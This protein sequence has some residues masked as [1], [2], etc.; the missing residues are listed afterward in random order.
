MSWRD[1]ARPII[2]RVLSETAGKPEAEIRKALFD[3]YPYGPRKYHP[4]K[5]WLHEIAVQR[6][7]KK[8]GKPFGGGGNRR[9]AVAFPPDPNQLELL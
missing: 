5:I 4:Y 6:G 7:K 8:L 1:S 2:A 9:S 3:A